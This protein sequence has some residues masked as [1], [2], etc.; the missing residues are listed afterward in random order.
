M[1]NR[2]LNLSWATKLVNMADKIVQGHHTRGDH[3]PARKL[4]ESVVAVIKARLARG[5]NRKHL[6]KEFGVHWGI[7]YKI[8]SGR[9][10]WYV[11]PAKI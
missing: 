4:S 11:E 1:D 3:N 2:R 6:A 9:N 10:W 7:M 5:E 8:A